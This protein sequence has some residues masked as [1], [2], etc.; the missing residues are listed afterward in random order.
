MP[1]T[2]AMPPP[3]FCQAG[4]TVHLGTVTLGDFSLM[5]P[6]QMTLETLQ[7]EQSIQSE[8]RHTNMAHIS[9]TDRVSICSHPKTYGDRR[10]RVSWPAGPA[11]ELT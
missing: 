2:Y 8:A 5:L 10:H 6:W 4:H 1:V 3:R 7:S 9:P 11:V